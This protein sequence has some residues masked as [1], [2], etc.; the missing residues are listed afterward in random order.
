MDSFAFTRLYGPWLEELLKGA[1]APPQTRADCNH[2]VMCTELRPPDPHDYYFNPG[3]RCCGYMPELPN[4]LVGGILEDGSASFAAARAQFEQEA[5]KMVVVPRTVAPTEW[6]SFMQKIRPFG[7]TPRILCPYSVRDRDGSPTCGI[8]PYRNAICMTW[9]C[10][11]DRM[12]TGERFWLELRRLLLAV[13]KELADW[14]VQQLEWKPLEF[15]KNVREAA[16]GNWAGR[17]RE[18]YMES[19]RLA[20]RLRWDDVFRIGGAPAEEHRDKLFRALKRLAATALPAAVHPGKVSR[21]L[22]GNGFARVWAYSRFD[23]VDIPEETLNLLHYFDGCSTQSALDRIRREE[24]VELEEATVFTL[25]D[26]G[27][28]T[29]T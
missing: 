8:W 1:A 16:W 15:P 5:V 26:A 22:L 17:E 12:Q 23:P 10:R 7:Q 24:G 9:F 18:F 29:A 4:F 25:L 2:C 28:L 19:H 3:I 20:A 27:I 11:Y 21:E 13:E 6:S 14:C